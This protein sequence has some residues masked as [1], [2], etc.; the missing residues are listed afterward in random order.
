M[1]TEQVGVRLKPTFTPGIFSSLDD[2]PSQ[3][4]LSLC[5]LCRAEEVPVLVFTVCR[6]EGVTAMEGWDSKVRF[7]RR[8]GTVGAYFLDGMGR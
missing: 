3:E 7:R 8:D 5:Q 2:R 1:A 4:L 6:Q